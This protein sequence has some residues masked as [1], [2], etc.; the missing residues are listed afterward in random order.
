MAVKLKKQGIL[1][2]WHCQR[3]ALEVLFFIFLHTKSFCVYASR[4]L[5]GFHKGKRSCL[6]F[7]HIG[8]SD[9]KFNTIFQLANLYFVHL[10]ARIFC[11]VKMP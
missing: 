2:L 3:A 10:D 7:V 9:A 1:R 8:I 5:P 11:I 4:K 6:I